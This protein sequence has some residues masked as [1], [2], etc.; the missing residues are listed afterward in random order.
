MTTTQPLAD[1][2][3]DRRGRP[4]D[5]GEGGLTIDRAPEGIRFEALTDD[6]PL[7]GDLVSPTTSFARTMPRSGRTGCSSTSRATSSSTSRSTC[8]CE[9]RRRWVAVLARPDRRRGGQ[10]VLGDR[11][12][13]L[14]HTG[15]LGVR[16][17]RHGDR[18]RR[19][20]EGRVRVGSEPL[21]VEL[22]LRLEPRHGRQ[23]RR[24]R[25]GHRWLRLRERARS[26]S[27][28]TWPGAAQR[29]V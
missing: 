18:R 2:A 27:R 1:D 29:R 7:L 10:P 12:A 23:R 13:R 19:W 24:A 25:L 26:G 15:A 28:T 5:M 22:V 9:R 4:R 8:E 3:R 17:C 20:R 16:Q 14:L 11:G 6:H 21:A